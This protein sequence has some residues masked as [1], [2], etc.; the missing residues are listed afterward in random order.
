MAEVT[1]A[2]YAGWDNCLHVQHEDLSLIITLDVGPRIL[3]CR[4]RDGPNLFCEFPD[5]LGARSGEDYMLFGGH[6]LWHAPEGK[7]RSYYPDFDPVTFDWQDAQLRLIQVPEATTGIRKEMEIEFLPGNQVL[8]RH[9]LTNTGLWSIE[10]APWAATLM[11]PGS[12]GIIPQEEYRPHPDYLAPARTITLW[13]FTRMNDPRI[14]WGERFIDLVEDSAVNQKFKLGAMNKSGW[15]A[16]W[17]YQT[18]FIKSFAFDA[19]ATYADMGCNYETFTM[20][21]FLEIETLGPLASLEP[22]ASVSHDEVWHFWPCD[23]LPDKQDEQALAA[24]LMPFLTDLVQP[25]N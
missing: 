20:P 23:K 13:H 1:C 25:E 12:R 18:L 22:Q 15:A 10:I 8:V 19:A 16:C 5:E 6:R 3:S 7:P 21:G 2:P 17:N 9:I 14:Y 24:A 4:F 11:A